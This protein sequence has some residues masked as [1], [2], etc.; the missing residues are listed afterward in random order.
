[1]SAKVQPILATILL[2]M[3]NHLQFF[4]LRQFARMRMQSDDGMGDPL[5]RGL[6]SQTGWAARAVFVTTLVWLVL[7]L[8]RSKKWDIERLSRM[9]LPLQVCLALVLLGYCYFY[10]APMFIGIK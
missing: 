2:W 4:I 9:V 1:M 10:T 3:L 6:I 8:L 5:G 7:V